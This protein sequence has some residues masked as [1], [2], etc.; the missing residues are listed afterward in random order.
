[1]GCDYKIHKLLKISHKNGIS[2]IELKSVRCYYSDFAIDHTD[3]DDDFSED[4]DNRL[5]ELNNIREMYLE[6]MLKPSKPKTLYENNLWTNK[7][8]EQKYITYIE[9]HIQDNESIELDKYLSF[10]YYNYKNSGEKLLDF[11]DITKIEKLEY[12]HEN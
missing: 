5:K 3:T 1:M 4:E 6:L 2:Y 10:N 9:Q 8:Y 12:R 7:V 11:K